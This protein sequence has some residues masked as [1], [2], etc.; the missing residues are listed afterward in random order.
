[1]QNGPAIYGQ[2]VSAIKREPY[3]VLAGLSRPWASGCRRAEE[4]VELDERI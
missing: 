2:S 3:Y 1:M 4:F